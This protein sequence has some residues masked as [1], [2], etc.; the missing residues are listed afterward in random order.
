M[1][2]KGGKSGVSAAV[3]ASAADFSVVQNETYNLNLTYRLG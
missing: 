1:Y 2:E 3:S